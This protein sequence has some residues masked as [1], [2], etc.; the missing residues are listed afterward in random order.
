M[1]KQLH[2]MQTEVA[3]WMSDTFDAATISNLPERA[4]RVLEEAAELAQAMGLGS[5]DAIAILAHVY[6]RP[7]EPD[8]AAEVGDVLITL[9]AAANAQDIDLGTAYGKRLVRCWQEQ[10][11]IKN[12]QTQ[13]P[14]PG[15]TPK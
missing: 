14:H 2:D 6:S 1:A 11:R 15:D 12:R 13:K 7:R 8:P 4:M 9:A 5:Q 10:A 3:F